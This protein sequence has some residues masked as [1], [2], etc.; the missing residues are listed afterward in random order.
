MF[1][2]SG[3][4][5]VEFIKKEDDLE[6]LIPKCARCIKLFRERESV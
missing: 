1:V 6:G 5:R 3:T 2:C 4:K